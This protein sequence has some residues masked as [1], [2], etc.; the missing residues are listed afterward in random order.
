[1]GQPV[2]VDGFWKDGYTIVKGVY[3][4]EEIAAFREQC[5][6]GGG[7]KG[8]DLLARPGLRS[9]LT[10]GAMIE[11]AR[12]ILG[13]DEIYYAGDSAF[14]I[15]AT[16]R[17]WHKDNADR[18]DGNAPDWRSRYTQLRFGIYLQDHTKHTGGLNLRKGS[19]EILSLKEGENIYVPF[20]PGDI[21]VWSMRITH[22]GNGQLIRFPRRKTTDPDD[23]DTKIPSWR[24]APKDGDRMAIF[25]ALGLDDEHAARYTDYLKTRKYAVDLWRGGPYSAEAL[26][27]ARRAGLK[28]RDVPSEVINDPNAGK[29]ADYAPIPY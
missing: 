24:M 21:G 14:T 7:A 20:E 5:R 3:S 19:H 8:G 18:T 15:N 16:G 2:D 22:S 4:P 12:K 13:K 28:V 25:A 9:V 1:M 6:A 11:I 17:G 26:E 10:D 23:K 27:E 29:N